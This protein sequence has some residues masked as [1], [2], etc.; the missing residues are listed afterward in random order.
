M[1]KTG[2]LAFLM[3][4]LFWGYS[5][6]K[7]QFE[8]TTY[9][10]GHIKEVDG[11][12]T[13]KF[14]FTNVGDS[15]L[16]L[17]TVK[18]GCGCTKGK[19][20]ETPIAPGEKGFIEATYDPFGR[21]GPFMKSITVT[22]NERANNTTILFIKG[23]VEKRP[24]TVFEEAGYLIGQGM[25]RFKEI[26]I[27]KEILNTEIQKDTFLIRNFGEKEVEVQ[28]VNLQDKPYLKEVYRSFN[29]LKPNEEGK[30][31]LQY[32]ASKRNAFGLLRDDISISVPEDN[33]PIKMLFYNVNIKEDFS[34][35][36]KKELE[37]APKITMDSLQF[38]F[39]QVKKNETVKTSCT[40]T[41]KGK[42]PLIIRDI[43]PNIYTVIPSVKTAT[44][45]PGG[46]LKIEFTYRGTGRAGEQKIGVDIIS[47]DPQN[48]ILP[49]QFSAVLSN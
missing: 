27:R 9:D 38:N 18:P 48:N 10:F 24:P 29:L 37:N 44:I 35:M 32:D 39:G 43:Q 17:L 49:I 11:S 42:S 15:I 30:I 41:N 46:F 47:N 2:L 3:S 31:V 16:E 12:V 28:F 20:T 25:V 34:K 6:P 36:T 45:A 8:Q 13:G 33:D 4:M 7:I 22:T 26:N 19:Y 14:V 21:P 5:Q 40:I 1:K 23:D